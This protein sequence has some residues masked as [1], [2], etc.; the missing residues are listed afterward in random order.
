MYYNNH[1][2]MNM[3]TLP[4]ETGKSLVPTDEIRRLLIPAATPK[5]GPQALAPT[6]TPGGSVEY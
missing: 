1:T 5:I 2:N 3:S 4:D 6:A